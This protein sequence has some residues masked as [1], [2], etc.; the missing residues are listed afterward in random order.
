MV[1]LCFKLYAVAIA[2][3]FIPDSRSK[4]CQLQK[5]ILTLCLV[6]HAKI[7]KT[8]QLLNNVKKKTPK[9]QNK[10]K[11]NPKRPNPKK[12]H[13]T[14]GALWIKNKNRI[15]RKGSKTIN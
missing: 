9:K 13:K 1:L 2:M 14:F 15:A 10:K 5:H 6:L 4:N 11:P 3:L 12:T 8:L 7:S